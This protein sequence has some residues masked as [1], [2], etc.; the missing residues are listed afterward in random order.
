MELE[1]LFRSLP[2]VPAIKTERYLSPVV[3]RDP[4]KLLPQPA[5]RSNLERDG[6]ILLRTPFLNVNFLAQV[7]PALF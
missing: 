4:V 1:T 3:Q 2:C 5:L 6:F 7:M